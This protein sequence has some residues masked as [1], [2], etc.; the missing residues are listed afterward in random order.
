MSSERENAVNQGAST[1][2]TDTEYAK[3]QKDWIQFRQFLKTVKEKGT[4]GLTSEI[5][6]EL[7]MFVAE[8]KGE[9]KKKRR[10][11]E[12]TDEESDEYDSVASE[13]DAS[14]ANDNKEEKYAYN[15]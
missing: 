2:N 5:E 15:Y 13:D 8:G 12:A 7:K 4:E 3:L 1:S 14:E 6:E 11:S 9:S 10:I